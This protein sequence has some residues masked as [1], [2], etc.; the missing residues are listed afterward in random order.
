MYTI[1]YWNKINAIYKIDQDMS[2]F[3]CLCLA[4]RVPGLHMQNLYKTYSE[5]AIDEY[6]LQT[7]EEMQCKTKT[8]N[9]LN[10]D[11]FEMMSVCVSMCVARIV[12]TTTGC[13]TV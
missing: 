7:L 10:F 13:T 11:C 2:H 5:I 12:V 3:T 6:V 1:L 9:L 4:N 8:N